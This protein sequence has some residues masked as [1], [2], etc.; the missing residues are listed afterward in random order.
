MH[1]RR[2][3][4]TMSGVALLLGLLVVGQLRGQVAGSSLSQQSAQDLTL[5]VANLNT[6]N[7][8][9]RGEVASLQQQLATL[10]NSR[11]HGA[12]VADQLRADLDRIQGWAGLRAVAG[13]GVTIRVS[14]PI[15]GDG[16]E[17]LLNEIR[18]GG[19]EAISVDGV[20]VVPGTVVA[21]IAGGLSIEN[22]ALGDAFEIRAIGSSQILTGSLTRAGGIIAQLSVTF[23][24]AT[25]SVTP[26]D[27]VSIPKT[28]RDLTPVHGH[29]SL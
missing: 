11:A 22:T 28:D 17:E 27:H 12:S 20:R 15:G 19:A 10:T 29:P 3:L 4:L 8:E 24:D 25:V 16:V 6:Q 9:L 7:E 2:N 26:M 1:K 23:P 5:L 13:Q 14:G 18:N 21:G